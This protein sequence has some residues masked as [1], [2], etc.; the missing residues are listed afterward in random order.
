MDSIP[1]TPTVARSPLSK[2]SF[3]VSLIPINS[4]LIST[5][6]IHAR[7]LK[8]I[9]IAAE[10]LKAAKICAGDILILRDMIDL[11]LLENLS[12]NEVNIN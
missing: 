4:S 9:Y 2:R 3:T 12:I 10:I 5:T 11:N 6:T 7:H 1:V 8:R